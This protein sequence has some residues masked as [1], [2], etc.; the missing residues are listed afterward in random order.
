MPEGRP[1]ARFRASRLG[2]MSAAD[3]AAQIGLEAQ[4]S[5]KRSG[6]QPC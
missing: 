4:N 1:R 5:S 3:S 2:E 6:P